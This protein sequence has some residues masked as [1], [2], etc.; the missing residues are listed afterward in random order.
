MKKYCVGVDPWKFTGT[1]LSFDNENKALLIG[2]ASGLYEKL[3]A[4]RLALSFAFLIV[5]NSQSRGL[6][7]ES[8][9]YHE[10]KKPLETENP[11]L[12]PLQL[13]D[14]IQ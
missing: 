3:I 9:A 1:S 11:S 13:P 7:L 2:I 12:S 4:R 5:T 10:S 6:L 14:Y 8:D